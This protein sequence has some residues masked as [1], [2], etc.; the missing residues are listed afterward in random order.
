MTPKIQKN[1]D[2]YEINKKENMPS[3]YY[4]KSPNPNYKK[5]PKI[6]ITFVSK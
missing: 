3:L 5:T 1:G 4:F 2:L 6:P